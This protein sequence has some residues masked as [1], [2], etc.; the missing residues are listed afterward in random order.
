MLT[1]HIARV[2]KVLPRLS[3]SPRGLDCPYKELKWNFEYFHI[4]QPLV[5]L[6]S[7][8]SSV[9]PILHGGQDRYV[10]FPIQYPIVRRVITH[11]A[12]T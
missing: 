1:C 5:Q 6:T 2:C 4:D 3:R 10:L 7:K 12:F 8:M 9:E 11:R